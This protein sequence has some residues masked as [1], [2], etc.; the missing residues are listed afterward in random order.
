MNTRGKTVAEIAAAKCECGEPAV[1]WFRKRFWCRGCLMVEEQPKRR[2][3]GNSS[4]YI[5]ISS[6]EMR[7]IFVLEF[8]E[9]LANK[10][11]EKFPSKERRFGDGM[12]LR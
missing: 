9:Q 11:R 1:E 10:M 12:E 7:R 4:A 8:R 6:E 2:I 5:P 3:W